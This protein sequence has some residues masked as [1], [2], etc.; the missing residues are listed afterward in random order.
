MGSG[1]GSSGLAIV[2][3]QQRVHTY[4]RN[5]SR[6]GMSPCPHLHIQRGTTAPLHPRETSEYGLCLLTL[7]QQHNKSR[8]VYFLTWESIGTSKR[9]IL[10]M[11]AWGTNV[12]SAKAR[13]NQQFKTK[14]YMF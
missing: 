12:T 1:G 2:D 8:G 13:N 3:W 4:F 9:S 14:S 5:A 11:W 6:S 7:S 10:V